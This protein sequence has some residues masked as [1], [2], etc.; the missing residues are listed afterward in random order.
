VAL[1]AGTAL[2]GGFGIPVETIGSR[3]GG[4][5]SGMPAFRYLISTWISYNSFCPLP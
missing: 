1:F 2:V 4:I 3:F 5:P